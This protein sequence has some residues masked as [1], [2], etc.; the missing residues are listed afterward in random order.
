ME[1]KCVSFWLSTT[2]IHCLRKKKNLNP[3]L[4]RCTITNLIKQIKWQKK[5]IRLDIANYVDGEEEEESGGDQS[6]D[7][8]DMICPM[9]KQERESTE[10]MK[11]FS[12]R[13]MLS[14]R[15]CMNK[16]SGFV[17]EQLM[18]TKAV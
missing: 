11:T 3:C 18:K 4:I 10:T 13:A 8:H 14:I 9:L 12:Y 16:E 17:Q 5:G 15:D 7:D 2:C 1:V 6:L